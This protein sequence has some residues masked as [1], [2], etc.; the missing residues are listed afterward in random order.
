MFFFSQYEVTKL[1]P[2][3]VH[4]GNLIWI[5]IISIFERSNLFQTIG[6]L[7]GLCHCNP[8]L[9]P[10]A[11]MRHFG[12]PCFFQGRNCKPFASFS[13]NFQKVRRAVLRKKTFPGLLTMMF[14][15]IREDRHE[16]DRQLKIYSRVVFLMTSIFLSQSLIVRKFLANKNYRYF[17]KEYMGQ[18]VFCVCWR[19]ENFLTGYQPFM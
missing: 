12:Y 16:I 13:F 7:Y 9:H 11:E 3:R 5:P 19:R 1:V 4:P 6:A 17:Q 15:A 8:P 14:P 18:L 2:W 10:L